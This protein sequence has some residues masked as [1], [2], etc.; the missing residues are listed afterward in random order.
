MLFLSFLGSFFKQVGE[1]IC[2]CKNW[3]ALFLL[4]L[5]LG[6]F[7]FLHFLVVFIAIV[8]AG[9]VIHVNLHLV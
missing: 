9:I 6:V 1:V 3:L 4:F 5:A 7:L 2:T 8:A